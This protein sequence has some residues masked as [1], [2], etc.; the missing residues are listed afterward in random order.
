[1]TDIQIKPLLVNGSQAAILLGMKKTAFY[2]NRSAIV[3]NGLKEVVMG[4]RVMY[5][6]KSIEEAVEHCSRTDTPLYPKSDSSQFAGMG[7]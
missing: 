2:K 5:T 1:M 7:K 4:G 3:A 6:V